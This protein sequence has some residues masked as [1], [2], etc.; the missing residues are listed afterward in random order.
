MVITSMNDRKRKCSLLIIVLDGANLSNIREAIPVT[1]H[2]P[3]DAWKGSP[4]IDYPSNLELLIAF[5]EDDE[6]FYRLASANEPEKLLK[7]LK[8]DH[9]GGT[10]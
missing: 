10:L 2:V 7:Y 5:E 6:E 9:G 3:T 4:S 1:L 8:R